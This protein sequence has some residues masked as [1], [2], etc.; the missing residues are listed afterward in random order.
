[1]EQPVRNQ[2]AP[3]STPAPGGRSGDL[4]PYL[5]SRDYEDY[6]DWCENQRRGRSRRGAGRLIF[7]AVSAFAAAFSLAG[8]MLRRR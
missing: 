2:G 7:G 1:M 4:S 8:T 3:V 6:L 5:L